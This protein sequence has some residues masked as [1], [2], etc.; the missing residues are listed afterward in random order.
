MRPPIAIAAALF[1]VSALAAAPDP[2]VKGIRADM[3]QG[4]FE[5]LYPDGTLPIDFTIGGVSSAFAPPSPPEFENGRLY[6]FAFLFRSDDYVQLRDAIKA[7]YPRLQ[8]QRSEVQN[9]MGATFQ[10]E[11][12]ALGHLS[13]AR[14]TTDLTIG[15]LTLISEQ[16]V[17]D[18]ARESKKNDKDI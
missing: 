13:I 1:A 16:A 14:F 17:K 10:Q 18:Q 6:R 5:Q 11:R 8:C 3:T 4:E 9:K 7:K 15:G 2:D 12:C